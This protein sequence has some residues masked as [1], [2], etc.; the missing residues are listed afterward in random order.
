[1]QVKEVQGYMAYQ[2]KD[3]HFHHAL[4][5]VGCSVLDNLDCDHL[6]RLQILAL[7]DLSKGSLTENV[8]DEIAVPTPSK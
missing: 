2:I 4:V 6:L 3:G 1:V 7:D 5:E 8:Q